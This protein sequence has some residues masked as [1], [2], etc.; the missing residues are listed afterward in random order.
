VS[1][2]RSI[3]PCGDGQQ[4]TDLSWSKKSTHF[5][6]VAEGNRQIHLFD[7][8]GGA[9]CSSIAGYPYMSNLENTKGHIASVHQVAFWQDPDAAFSPQHFISTAADGTVRLWDVKSMENSHLC[10]AKVSGIGTGQATRGAGRLDYGSALATLY[11]RNLICVGTSQSGQVFA[12]DV[13]APGNILQLGSPI[14]ATNARSALPTAH[15]SGSQISAI[16]LSN[17]NNTCATRACDHYLKF[18]DLRKPNSPLY[19]HSDLPCAPHTSCIFSQ[20]NTFLVTAADHRLLFFHPQSGKLLEQVDVGGQTIKIVYN[21]KVNQYALGLA[22]GL[23]KLLYSP[24]LSYNG[25]LLCNTSTKIK[26]K[27]H[28]D[29]YAHLTQPEPMVFNSLREVSAIRSNKKQKTTTQN[30]GPSK[31][32]IVS[33]KSQT[34]TNSKVW[35]QEDP[36]EALLKYA[37]PEKDPKKIF[38]HYSDDSDT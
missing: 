15:Q 7:R 26:R 33:T 6:C 3:Q 2:F 19:Q 34:Q 29:E 20:N 13:R 30:Y 4:I 23:I 35:H 31:P 18:W 25:A 37:D 28:I 14:C 5:L 11:H 24:Q 32:T 1:P 9:K 8:D 10:M 36:R 21:Q 27:K 38:S 12:F 22:N 17:D 16:A